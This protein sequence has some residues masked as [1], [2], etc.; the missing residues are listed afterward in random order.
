MAKGQDK[1]GT[2]VKLQV[3]GKLNDAEI[4]KTPFVPAHYYKAK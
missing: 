2:K 3:R 4:V 1:V